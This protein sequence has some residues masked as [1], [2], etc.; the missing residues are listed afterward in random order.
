MIRHDE[1]R[2]LAGTHL[3]ASRVVFGAM[4]FGS[5]VDE[6]EAAR[7]VDRCRQA[8]VTTFDTSNNY[9]EGRSEEILGRLVRPFRDGVLIC[10]KAGSPSG[11]SDPEL[12]GLSRRGIVRSVDQSLQRLGTDYID[13]FYLH[14]PDPRT[15]IE[16]T[17]EALSEIKRLGKVRAV[18]QSNY[19]AWQIMEM[20]WLAEREGW[21]PPLIS[22]PMFNLLARRLED[23]YAACSQQLGLSNIVYN[24]LAGGL[25]TGKHQ[26]SARPADGTRFS[27]Q[28]YRDRYWSPEL[29]GAVDELASVAADA[30]LTLIQLAF[31]W[32][33]AQPI[34]DCVL[35][36]ASSLQQLDMNLDAID[37]AGPDAE[38]MRRCD[39]VWRRL[40]GP[41]PQYN[42]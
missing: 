8:G 14:C 37:G 29:F 36:G 12:A 23:E 3:R 35:L 41:A 10:T 17:L 6:A 22:Q 26:L 40:R 16:E 15:P 19:A 7:M 2:T 28:N 11:Q 25:L 31:R 27:R 34:V 21:P 5:Q 33:L 1:P 30:G 9:N 42:R 18:G 38:T 32:L 39:D 4:T 13:V 20:K 24:P